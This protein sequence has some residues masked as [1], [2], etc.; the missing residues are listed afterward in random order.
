[1]IISAPKHHYPTAYRDF[2]KHVEHTNGQP[3]LLGYP[4]TAAVG[5][6]FC[7]RYRIAK[8]F[9]S[10][11]LEGYSQNT[12]DGYSGLF[13]AFLAFSA[14]ELFWEV[15]GESQHSIPPTMDKERCRLLWKHFEEHDPDGVFLGFLIEKVNDSLRGRLKALKNGDTLQV[16]YL[17]AAVRHIFGH[18]HLSAQPKGSDPSKI[19]EAC[20]LLF[21]FIVEYMDQRFTALVERC[22]KNI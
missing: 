22:S 17:V 11:E 19:A 12:V 16:V 3:S 1:M 21:D 2:E 13:R 20:N 18:G 4:C 15:I 6:R 9:K 5:Y 10:I 8:S 14:Y 7:N